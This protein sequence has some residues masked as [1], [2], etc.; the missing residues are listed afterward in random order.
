MKPR[1]DFALLCQSFFSKRLIAQRQASA[2]TVSAYAQTFRLLMAYAQRR[3]RTP[4]SQLSLTQLDAPFIA[5]W[6]LLGM[7]IPAFIGAL[8]GPRLLRW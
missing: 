5:L 8:L 6:Y 4:P 2:H 7:L 1:P 3:L